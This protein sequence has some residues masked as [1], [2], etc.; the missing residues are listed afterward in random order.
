MTLHQIT[1]VWVFSLSLYWLE[2]QASNYLDVCVCVRSPIAATCMK[3]TSVCREHHW[4]SSD[5]SSSSPSLLY[6]LPCTPNLINLSRCLGM[7][8]IFIQTF[9]AVISFPSTC[10]FRMLP[11]SLAPLPSSTPSPPYRPLIRCTRVAKTKSA[12]LSFSPHYFV[13]SQPNNFASCASSP[14]REIR[15]ASLM[16]GGWKSRKEKNK[17]EKWRERWVVCVPGWNG[18]C[19]VRGEGGKALFNWRDVSDRSLKC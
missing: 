15:P 14:K 17:R 7:L 3:G 4:S 11:P 8:G 13:I 5:K 2:E 19:G 1:N 9:L 6:L 10:I 16:R 18:S 12:A